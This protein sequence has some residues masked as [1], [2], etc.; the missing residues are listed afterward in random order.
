MNRKLQS[1]VL[2]TQHE[3][4]INFMRKLEISKGHAALNHGPLDLPSNALPLSYIPKYYD[5]QL[6][7]PCYG[8]FTMMTCR[9]E[10]FLLAPR[11]CNEN[12]V[13]F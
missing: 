13:C 7:N 3:S 5:E 4:R 6:Q 2:I 1:H 12:K 10:M 11:R 9:Q 8:H